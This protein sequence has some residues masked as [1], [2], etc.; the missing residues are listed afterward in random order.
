[1]PK[2]GIR[3]GSPGAANTAGV[4]TA[5]SNEWTDTTRAA[6]QPEVWSHRYDQRAIFKD[7]VCQ[8]ERDMRAALTSV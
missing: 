4:E 8:D 2:H 6:I 3:R 1:M 7:R 5:G